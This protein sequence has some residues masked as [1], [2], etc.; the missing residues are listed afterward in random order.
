MKHTVKHPLAP[1]RAR[2]MLTS[3]LDTYR[4]HYK[5]YDL[6]TEWKDDDTA[7]VDMCIS[8]RDIKG[9]VKVCDG[10]YEVDMDLPLF[11]R[12]FKGRIRKGLDE[13]IERWC[14]Q[15]AE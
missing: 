8:G 9:E 11:F 5:D 15:W 12:P 6:K 7:T 13:E 1:E 14:E 3:L 4:D 10:T 2:Q